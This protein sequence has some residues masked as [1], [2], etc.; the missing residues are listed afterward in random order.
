MLRKEIRRHTCSGYVAES[1]F[2]DGESGHR[3]AARAAGRSCDDNASDH[4]VCES[5][6]DS[7]ARTLDAEQNIDHNEA[8]TEA[9]H[10]D[11][12]GEWQ[13]SHEGLVRIG[14]LDGFDSR[15]L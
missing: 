5:A 15:G 13:H 6:G 3:S 4:T 7:R 10:P 9:E 11:H 8:G 14:T 1:R 12:D 2:A